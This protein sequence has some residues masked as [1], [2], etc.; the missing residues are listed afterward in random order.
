MTDRFHADL[1]EHRKPVFL[2]RLQ[3]GDRRH[4]VFTSRRIRRPSASRVRSRR[5]TR[6]SLITSRRSS[7]LRCTRRCLHGPAERRRS[8]SRHARGHRR[9]EARVNFETYVFNDGEI[10]D[11]FVDA[12]VRAAQRGVVVRIVLDPIG[13]S[14]K[15]KSTR[16]VESRRCEARLVQSAW[17]LERSKTTTTGPIARRSSSTATSPSPAG[18]AS[19]ITGSATHR[20][21]ITG[22]TRISRSPV[23]R[24]ARSKARSTRTGSNPAGSRRRRS[25]R[26]CR[27]CRPARARSWCGAIPWPAPATSSCM[28]L[29]A[30]GAARKTIDIQSPYFTLDPST[31]WSLDQLASAA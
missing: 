26:K 1:Q 25:I 5:P 4:P 8:V 23:P 10:A 19:P 17:L 20:T 29:L 21:R 31:Q 18:W 16:R 28:Y 27:R 30:I 3:P 11:R 22:A 13:S 12:L 24:S 2:G 14:L 9:R 7:A 6:G 15:S